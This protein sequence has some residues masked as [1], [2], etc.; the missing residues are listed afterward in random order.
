MNKVY[1]TDELNLDLIKKLINRDILVACIHNYKH[2]PNLDIINNILEDTKEDSSYTFQNNVVSHIGLSS[3]E[4]DMDK[5]R[6]K[7][8]YNGVS[9]NDALID[10]LFS[11]EINPVKQFIKDLNKI[12]PQGACLDRFHKKDMF[13]GII[14]TIHKGSMIHAHQDLVSWSNPNADNIDSVTHQFGLNYFLKVPNEGGHLLVWDKSL[15]KTEFDRQAKGGFC[16]PIEELPPP[17]IKVK[18]RVGMLTLLN[19]HC[20]HAIER[21]YDADRIAMSCFLSYRT[22]D[23]P[24]KLWS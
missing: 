7:K 19:T 21:N 2:Y 23:E 4:I 17:D 15:E 5:E 12:W 24:L 6:F 1:E 8:Y 3:Y 10:S 9:E 13:A 22:D 18:P 11:P 16:I 14:R 20:L